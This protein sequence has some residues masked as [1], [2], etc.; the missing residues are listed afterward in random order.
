M[1]EAWQALEG[2]DREHIPG[3]LLAWIV[4]GREHSGS[5]WRREGIGILGQNNT[6]PFGFDSKMLANAMSS[7]DMEWVDEIT[8]Y[9]T[10]P[11]GP[12]ADRGTHTSRFVLHSPRPS[13]PSR[14]GG[15]G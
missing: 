11:R 9:R 13:V 7:L 14:G 2:A 6:H 10:L 3:T 4:G 15:G 1:K 5:M 12:E 8:H